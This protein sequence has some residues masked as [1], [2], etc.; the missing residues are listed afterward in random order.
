[1]SITQYLKKDFISLSDSLGS[2]SIGII[3]SIILVRHMLSLIRLYPNIKKMP[4]SIVIKAIKAE[5][6]P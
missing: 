2:S 5:K 1:M 3:L 4:K 6:R